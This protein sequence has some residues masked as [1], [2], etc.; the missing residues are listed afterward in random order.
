[1]AQSLLTGL[2]VL[3]LGEGVSAAYCAKLL[4]QLGARVAKV[5][6]PHGDRA[7]RAGP[8]PGDQPHPERS[9]LFLALNVNKYGVTADLTTDEGRRAVR[10]LASESDVVV[11]NLGTGALDA[12]GLGYDDLA[13]TKPSLV[14]ASITPYGPWSPRDGLPATD[15]TL[16]HESGHAHALLGPVD[17]PDRVPPVRAGG[18]QSHL[19]AGLAAATAVLTA[20]YRRQMT[21][22]GARVDVSEY[23]ALATQLI[24][25]FAGHAYGQPAASR[26]R[27]KIGSVGCHRGRAAVQRRPRRHLAAGGGAVEAVAR[28]D[29][30]PRM[31][32]GRAIRYAGRQGDEHRRALGV[33]RRLDEPVLEARSR[34]LGAGAPDS[35]LSGQHRRGPV[36]GSPPCGEGVLQR[37]GAS[38]RGRAPIPR[39]GLPAVQLRERGQPPGGSDARPAQQSADAVLRSRAVCGPTSGR[40]GCRGAPAGTPRRPTGRAAPGRRQGGRPELD[41]RGAD[42]G[43]VPGRDGRGGH[44]GGQ[45]EAARPIVE[46]RR[47]PGVQPVQAVLRPEHSSAQPVSHSRRS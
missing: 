37:T 8:F 38:G 20:I 28:N 25:S 7:R 36:H 11:E 32:R 39:R 10:S 22:E 23:E 16:F 27:G 6:P 19:A 18:W 24:A 1:M 12:L 40:R 31:G 41:H 4:G 26:D 43:E 2:N 34:S 42:G 30:Q 29:G 47:I 33:A 3:E 17:D 35:V 9:A 15:L 5:E 21:G 14:Y 45:R 44:Q 46:G 13:A